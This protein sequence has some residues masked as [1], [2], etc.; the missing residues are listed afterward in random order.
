V[1]GGYGWI[2]QDADEGELV[3]EHR[4]WEQLVLGHA[5]GR[6]SASLRVRQEQ[7]LREEELNHRGRALARLGV[8]LVGPVSIQ[9][10]DE[11]FFSFN[12]TA[13]FP[14]QGYDQNRFFVG[15]SIEGFR[16]FRLEVGYLN[17]DLARGEASANN[18][19]LLMSA[20]FSIMPGGG[21]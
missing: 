8:K 10:W 7:R 21:G 12:G 15:P 9:V 14:Y 13:W 4:A 20:A 3:S 19:V 16:G 1:W 5:A 6:L 11:A 2:A 17:H 18:H